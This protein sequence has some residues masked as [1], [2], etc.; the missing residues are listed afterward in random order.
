MDTELI[1]ALQDVY[2]SGK[3]RIFKDE[4]IN[5]GVPSCSIFRKRFDEFDLFQ[6]VVVRQLVDRVFHT[7]SD[8]LEEAVRRTPRQWILPFIM[9]KCS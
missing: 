7:K 6:S 9:Q 2:R 3:L 1:R 4:L 8:G 5:R